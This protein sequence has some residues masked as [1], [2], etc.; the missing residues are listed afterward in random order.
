MRRRGAWRR[1]RVITKLPSAAMPHS[2]SMP[3][4][5]P[6]GDEGLGDLGGEHESLLQRH[7]SLV[8]RCPE[9]HAVEILL[10]YE[11]C[12][13]AGFALFGADI[14]HRSDVR[15]IERRRR[16]R[17]LLES[18]QSLRIGGEL[19]RQYLDRHLAAQT[20]VLGEVYLTHPTGAE[21]VEILYGPRE[22]PTM[23]TLY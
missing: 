21:R 1:S 2:L 3:S 17:L 12:F 6:T 9:R 22:V 7:R 23:P 18:R 16:P 4:N 14:E 11:V 15:M 19:D 13:F 5:T 8:E 10:H 20:G